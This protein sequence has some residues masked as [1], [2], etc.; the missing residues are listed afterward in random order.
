MHSIQYAMVFVIF[1]HFMSTKK[2]FSRNFYCLFS[3]QSVE[4][5]QNTFF[6]N[7]FVFCYFLYVYL[8]ENH[9]KL[10]ATT[11]TLYTAGEKVKPATTINK[12]ADSLF[13]IR[14]NTFFSCLYWRTLG[15]Q[16]G[17]DSATYAHLYF[18]CLFL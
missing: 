2:K 1:Q 9:A 6:T 14:S 16:F 12:N 11:P 5:Q 15:R 8:K 7:V 13:Y 4:Q 18:V 10:S 17:A 3:V